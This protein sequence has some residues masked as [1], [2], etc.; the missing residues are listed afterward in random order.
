VN[1]LYDGTI[2]CFSTL[3]QSSIA[4]NETF[5][6]K[7]ALQQSDYHEFVKAVIHEVNNH[8]KQDHWTLTKQCNPPPGTKT[9]LSI[10][11]FKQKH[12]RK[13]QQDLVDPW[14]SNIISNAISNVNLQTTN[15]FQQG[16]TSHFDNGCFHKF[17][18]NSVSEGAQNP[19]SMLIVGCRYSKIF[20]HFYKHCRIF[21]EGVKGNGN[22]IVKEH[23]SG[24]V[25]L[26]G[27]CLFGLVEL[28]LAF[29]HNSASGPAFGQNMAS[30]LAFGHNLAFGPA[31]GHNLAFGLAFGHNL[32]SGPA[33]G[34]NLAYGPAFG[35]NELVELILAIGHTNGLISHIALSA[36]ALYWLIGLAV[37]QQ[38]LVK[39]ALLAFM[40]LALLASSALSVLLASLS[41]TSSASMASSA[42]WAPLAAMASAASLALAL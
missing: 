29:G 28:I 22:G 14:S 21:C 27:L 3:A 23:P 2:N 36:S 16:F 31:S 35:H 11:R 30:G 24:I 5:A 6:Y 17:I 10:W 37:L 1:S 12:Q 32:A 41:A 19:L 25:S 34:H 8:E 33:S 7:V 4:S 18:V 38:P 42:S 15:N 39:I 20:L 40:A 13:P 9:I 26:A